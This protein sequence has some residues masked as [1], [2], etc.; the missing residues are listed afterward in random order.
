MKSYVLKEFGHTPSKVD[1]D[2]AAAL[3]VY[4]TIRRAVDDKKTAPIGRIVGQNRK[5]KAS[6]GVISQRPD[7]A[8]M[9]IL[10]V[11]KDHFLEN[12][13]VRFNAFTKFKSSDWDMHKP[14]M[15]ACLGGLEAAYEIFYQRKMELELV[16]TDLPTKMKKCAH[17]IR[18]VGTF[19]PNSYEQGRH[20]AYKTVILAMPRSRQ[21]SLLEGATF[22]EQSYVA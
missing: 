2:F 5:R 10:K 19:S 7:M 14:Q 22:A 20:Y 3:V 9:I 12:Y 13:G 15:S 16:L 6:L 1:P 8:T 4:Q 21:F 11:L 17:A 18:D